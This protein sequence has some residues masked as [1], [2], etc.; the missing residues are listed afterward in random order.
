[1]ELGGTT[2]GG[3]VTTRSGSSPW[4][5]VSTAGHPTGGGASAGLPR[6][7]PW[8]TQRAMVAISAS[9]SE[10]SSRYLPTVRSANQGG[11]TRAATRCL[12]ERAHGRTS[13]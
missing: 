11:M 8:S 12:M 4:Y 6:G 7:A 3:L 5:Q 9:L 13:S 1:M 2:T 10:G